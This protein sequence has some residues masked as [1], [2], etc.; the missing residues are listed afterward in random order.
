MMIQTVSRITLAALAFAA[1]AAFA[2]S[3]TGSGKSA[4]ETRAVS[5]FS[6]IGFS[7][8]GQLELNQG[9]QESVV[10]TADDN[11][12]PEVETVV[13][14]GMLKIRFRKENLSTSN[15]HIHV[16]VTARTLEHVAVGGSGDIRAGA[17]KVGKLSLSVGG[18]GNIVVESLVATDLS[19]QVGGSGNITVKG[20]TTD[21]LNA[22]IGGSGNVV[23]TR[24]AT[25]R[26]SVNVGGSG[27]AGVWAS[28][29]L[30]ANVAGSGNVTYYGD[31]KVSRAIVGS[32]DVKRLGASPS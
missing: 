12:L 9:D 29:S 22:S 28:E 30:S 27:N 18:S 2:A 8:P 11:V 13:E 21:T 1:S 17:L 19:A 24:L 10:I 5:G 4:T 25:R 31:A 26:A 7:V 20:G 32:G 14:K 15:V 6:G 3:L 16:K 23:A